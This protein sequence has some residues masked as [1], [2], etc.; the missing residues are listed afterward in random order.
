MDIGASYGHAE[1]RRSIESIEGR[2]VCAVSSGGRDLINIE[3][4]GV[5]ITASGENAVYRGLGGAASS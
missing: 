5:S 4:S 2:Y 1:N 3:P